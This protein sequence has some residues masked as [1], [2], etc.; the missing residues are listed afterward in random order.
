MKKL[1]VIMAA[2]LISLT[3]VSAAMADGNWSGGGEW[4]GAAS[5]KKGE[6][7]AK[8]FST[9]IVNQGMGIPVYEVIIR[10][11]R[12]FGETVV[13]LT[14]NKEDIHAYKPASIL[15]TGCYNGK[16]D[17]FESRFDVFNDNVQGVFFTSSE[18]SAG[19]PKL[20]ALEGIVTWSR[21]SK[22]PIDKVV[23]VWDNAM[24]SRVYLGVDFK[25]LMGRL[26]IEGLTG[27]EPMPN[28]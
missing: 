13:P 22:R 3:S 10:W 24:R 5:D 1:G 9:R 18:P 19:K 28:Y 26:G 21:G 8:R 12:N 15:W 2:I 6:R 14:V 20:Y 27:Y 17:E 11:A 23:I 25:T 4:L 7:L 16:A